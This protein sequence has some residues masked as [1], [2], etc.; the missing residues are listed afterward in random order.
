ML[1]PRLPSILLTACLASSTV[2]ATGC[3]TVG[4]PGESPSPSRPRV[5]TDRPGL[6]DFSAPG[7]TH[8]LATD[9]EALRI[10]LI[11]WLSREGWPT[12]QE[13]EGRYTYVITVYVEEGELDD[14]ATPAGVAGGGSVPPATR[15][16]P[17]SS[18]GRTQRSAV[19]LRITGA[20]PGAG[21]C[22]EAFVSWTVQSRGLREETWRVT[23]AD[24]S[25]QPSLA[26]V[27]ARWL[28]ER[29]GCG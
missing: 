17:A 8:L 22:S 23:D 16:R 1:G 20:P 3:A 4:V 2:L 19:L 12:T 26:R 28:G 27:I 7:L 6:D 21:P 13:I 29:P 9:P 18:R 25:T 24:R 15:W 10:E 11:E 5:W 14:G